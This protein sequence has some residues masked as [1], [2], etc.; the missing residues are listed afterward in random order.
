MTDTGLVDVHA[1]FTTDPYIAAAKAA[2]H[3]RADGMPEQHWPRWSAEEHL[4]LMDDL[5]IARSML[6]ISSPGVH[7]GDDA[8]ARDLARSVNEA[9]AAV[10]ARH[11]DRFGLFASLPLPD[12]AGALDELRHAFDD[13]RAD[14]VVLMSNS[15]GTYLGDDRTDPLLA[16]L[17]RRRGVAFLHPTSAPGH[18]H[19]DLGYPS[20][21]IEF[22]FD[23]AR[24]VLSYVL[25]G[26]AERYP[27]IRVVVPHG[28]GVLPLLADR[29]EMF[30]ALLGSGGDRTVTDQLRGFWYELAGT[31]GALRTAALDAVAAP[32]HLLYG[33]DYPWTPAGL[34]GDLLRALDR[35][36]ED[37]WRGRTT[38]NAEKLFGGR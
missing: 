27:N 38:G 35:V 30:R 13:L 33:S 19:T 31:P 25:S 5:G 28:G 18:E 20:P 9:G 4:R 14:G 8:A 21:M 23:T 6:S 15:R 2:G 24:A 34:A 7:F 10:V 37:G 17:D 26:A 36:S 32:D 16:E 12:V 11:P 22:L 1:H 3:V 29:T